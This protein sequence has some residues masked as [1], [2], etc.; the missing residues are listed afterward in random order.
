MKGRIAAKGKGRGTVRRTCTECRLDFL[1][2]CSSTATSTTRPERG[3]FVFL[4]TRISPSLLATRH[5]SLAL[6][7]PQS[8]PVTQTK[9]STRRPLSLLRP[10]LNPPPMYKFPF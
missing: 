5:R 1:L 4:S 8:H 3:Y 6:R 9:A 2:H 7:L 10:P